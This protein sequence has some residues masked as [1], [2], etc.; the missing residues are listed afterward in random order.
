MEALTVPEL[1]AARELDSSPAVIPVMM[2]EPVG[3]VE[4][5]E[6]LVASLAIDINSAKELLG[7]SSLLKIP[8]SDEGTIAVGTEETGEDVNMLRILLIVGV[9]STM[10]AVG[11]CSLLRN[12]EDCVIEGG[13]A[14]VVSRLLENDKD[15]GVSV[16]LVMALK[17]EVG[18]GSI[19]E[20]INDG[21]TAVEAVTTCRV[22]LLVSTLVPVALV[23]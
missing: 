19:A 7:P 8:G 13:R 17:T 2:A 22:V 4:S 15:Q 3:L 23:S 9:D 12:S 5:L 20:D 6:V 1:V 21:G 10:L 11:D 16:M 18:L 14:I